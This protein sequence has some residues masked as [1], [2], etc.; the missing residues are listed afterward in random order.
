LHFLQEFVKKDLTFVVPYIKVHENGGRI[1]N[2]DIKSD[3]LLTSK[4]YTILVVDDNPQNL[5]V[6][7]S[8]L[9]EQGFNTLIASR[10]ELAL[11][12][13]QYAHPDLM[14]C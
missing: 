4:E 12:R 13:R 3:R 8:Y 14:V 1:M 5:K 2:L 11:K 6:I 9:R 7:D 10:G